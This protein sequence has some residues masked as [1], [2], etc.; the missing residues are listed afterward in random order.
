MPFETQR[1]GLDRKEPVSD[2]V[3][4]AERR[5]HGLGQGYQVSPGCLD[6]M[7]LDSADN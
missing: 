4:R 7:L 3:Y 5:W 6:L 1:V 2:S